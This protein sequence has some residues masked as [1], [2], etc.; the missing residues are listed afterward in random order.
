MLNM[1]TD[2]HGKISKAVKARE[3]KPLLS[4]WESAGIVSKRTATNMR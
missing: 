2:L 1:A 3:A 4:T